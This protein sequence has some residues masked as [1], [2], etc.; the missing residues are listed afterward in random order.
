[1]SKKDPLLNQLGMSMVEI[2][3][4][5]GLLGGL[6]LGV[7]RLMENSTKA[8][9]TIEAKDEISMLTNQINDVLKNPN[10]CEATFGSK[11]EGDPI[12]FVYQVLGGIFVP[13]FTAPATGD[14]KV[15]I[16][17][18]ALKDIDSNGSNGSSALATF[19]VTFKKPDKTTY[20]ARTIKRE[21]SLNANLCKKNYIENTDS[22][23]L[24]ASCTGANKLLLAGP[25][26]W[27]G[28]NWIIC[29]DC[30]NAV[31]TGVI[32]TCAS[33]GSGG[34]V[35]LADINSNTCTQ[36]GGVYDSNKPGCTFNGKSF[37][38]L[39]SMIM[40][41]IATLQSS[42]NTINQQLLQNPSNLIDTTSQ[43]CASGSTYSLIVESGKIRLK[44]EAPT[45][46]SGCSAW[47][48]WTI[49][50]KGSTCV[51]SCD[52]SV[53]Q[54]TRTT[55]RYTRSCN[56]KTPSGCVGSI[57]NQFTGFYTYLEGLGGDKYYNTSSGRTNA[58]Q[59]SCPG[60][61]A[62]GI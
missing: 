17:S 44:C 56:T 21:I 5:A 16:Q 9:K 36:F 58:S 37:T 30:T 2:M 52:W 40:T 24:L 55:C 22:A 39:I 1:M 46:C 11:K 8:A 15:Q 31:T 3:V 60:S 13:K 20:G 12:F 59:A 28:T 61:G 33:S 25:N 10:N 62:F 50:D 23:A 54:G 41:D 27:S 45:V 53:K 49:Y 48:A 32:N 4:A 14:S 6:S 26:A 38:E 7:M 42:V 35:D 34:G 51:Y 19:E 57:A 43:V 29:Q 47:S 18:M